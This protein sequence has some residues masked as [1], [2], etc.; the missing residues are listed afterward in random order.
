MIRRCVELL[1]S[2]RKNSRRDSRPRLFREPSSLE[3]ERQ[4]RYGVETGLALVS[5]VPM[6]CSR[7]RTHCAPRD[8]LH[9]F[10]YLGSKAQMREGV[11]YSTNSYCGGEEPSGCGR[12]CSEFGGASAGRAGACTP[13]AGTGV[14]SSLPA[15][16]SR[17]FNSMG[18]L[19]R[20]F[21]S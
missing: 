20:R 2:L 15:S 16:G 7:A 13:T 19:A 10:E 9:S 14:A 6:N 1:H 8:K 11:G 5:G 21:A 4:E 3:L 12:S 17:C 18:L